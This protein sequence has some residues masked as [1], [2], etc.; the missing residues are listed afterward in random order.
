MK[1][2]KMPKT[3]K[4][5]RMWT[6]SKVRE[7]CIR[8]NLYTMGSNTEYSEM[9]DYVYEHKNPDNN[10]IYTVAIDI[11]NHSEYQTLENV[12]FSLVRDCVYTFYEF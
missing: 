1:K 4:I 9:L 3:V 11:L 7:M 6:A 10:D 8:M 5:E 12:M 2:Q